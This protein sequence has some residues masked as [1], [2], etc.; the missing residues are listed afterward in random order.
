MKWV[1]LMPSISAV[2]PLSTLR[3]VMLPRATLC[4]VR[5]LSDRST[6]LWS[7]S[8]LSHEGN[9]MGKDRRKRHQRLYV[10]I[11]WGQDNELLNRSLNFDCKHSKTALLLVF[12]LFQSRHVN[13]KQTQTKIDTRTTPGI[14]MRIHSDSTDACLSP[15]K[16]VVLT[17]SVCDR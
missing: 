16:K 10:S 9:W 4:E 6:H 2:A 14:G 8:S 5:T 17:L 3:I 15:L 7:V 11:S 13:K 1:R 12:L